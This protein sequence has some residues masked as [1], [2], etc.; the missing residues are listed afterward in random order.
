M[1]VNGV[2]V[3]DD[4]V[5]ELAGAV[6]HP[7]LAHK[8]Q[9]AHRFRSSVVNLS[10]AERT[11]VLADLD[12]PSGELE[13]LRWGLLGGGRRE[14]LPLSLVRAHTRVGRSGGRLAKFVAVKPTACWT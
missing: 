1:I 9:T 3:E 14:R 12:D 11:L 5:L 6:K 7:A 4:R 8:L 13:K 2:T 10:N